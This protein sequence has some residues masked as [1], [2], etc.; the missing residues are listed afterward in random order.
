MEAKISVLFLELV[1]CRGSAPGDRV[2]LARVS[3]RCRAEGC[4]G[5]LPRGE[6]AQ[7][8]GAWW[9]RPKVAL[10]FG[11]APSAPLHQRRAQEAVPPLPVGTCLLPSSPLASGLDLPLPETPAGSYL[12]LP[13]GAW[14]G[15][16]R[17]LSSDPLGSGCLSGVCVCVRREADGCASDLG[18]ANVGGA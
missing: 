18:W 1:P 7:D 4:H 14:H 17:G 9:L 13:K 3:R 15:C 10:G 5:Q 8:T 16:W 12:T 6:W 2:F 11:R